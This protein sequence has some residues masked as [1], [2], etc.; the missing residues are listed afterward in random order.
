MGFINQL[1]TGGPHIVG[2]WNVLA[3]LARKCLVVIVL[4]IETLRSNN[5]STVMYPILYVERGDIIRYT[6]NI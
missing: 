5:V 6:T 2:C 1:I 3:F 4:D